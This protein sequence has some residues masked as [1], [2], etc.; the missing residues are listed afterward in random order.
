MYDN[1]QYCMQHLLQCALQ[2]EEKRL[3][4]TLH[5]YYFW[6]ALLYLYLA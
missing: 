3:F 5:L 6:Q 2:Y 1:S 4:R